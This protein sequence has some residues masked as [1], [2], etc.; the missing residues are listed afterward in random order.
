MV[1]LRATV[2]T[3]AL[4]LW[5]IVSEAGE[6][7]R[8]VC[9]EVEDKRKRVRLKPNPSGGVLREQLSFGIAFIKVY[10]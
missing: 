6:G 1:G 3:C 9:G 4:L 10:F 8:A 5:G 2:H 7:V